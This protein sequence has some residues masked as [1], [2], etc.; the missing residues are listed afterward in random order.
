MDI[1]VEQGKS[2]ARGRGKIVVIEYKTDEYEGSEEKEVAGMAG[3]HVDR[4]IE[5]IHRY[6]TVCSLDAKNQKRR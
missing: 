4:K 5:S 1:D 3:P 2:S 6:H